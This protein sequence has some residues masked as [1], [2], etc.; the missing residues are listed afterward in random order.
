[1]DISKLYSINLK[2]VTKGLLVAV[3]IGILQPVLIILKSPGFDFATANWSVIFEVA[4]NGAIAGFASY[5]MKNFFSD[6]E[7]K[8]LGKF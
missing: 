8:V 7:G 5:L 4:T 1:M 3:L 2:D 6:E